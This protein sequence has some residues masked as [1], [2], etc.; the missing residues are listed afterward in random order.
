MAD[1]TPLSI[2][3]PDA[4]AVGGVVVIQE[5]FGVTPHIEDVCQRLAD[6]G[7]LAV[8]PTCSGGPA[9]PSCPTT[10]SARCAPTSGR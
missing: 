2:H 6:A 10:T 5:V 7:W 9:T 3:H 8:G 4:G 1:E